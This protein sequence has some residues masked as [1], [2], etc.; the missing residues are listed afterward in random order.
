MYTRYPEQRKHSGWHTRGETEV[1]KSNFISAFALA[2][3]SVANILM[4]LPLATTELPTCNYSLVIK[5]KNRVCQNRAT[6]FWAVDNSPRLSICSAALRSGKATF[7]LPLVL[8][9]SLWLL[10]FPSR[11]S[12]LPWSSCLFCFRLYQE[13]CHTYWVLERANRCSCCRFPVSWWHDLAHLF[14]EMAHAGSPQSGLE[15]KRTW[16]EQRCTHWTGL[17]GGRWLAYVW[18]GGTGSA[19]LGSTSNFFWWVMCNQWDWE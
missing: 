8:V 13:Q 9:A 3:F 1:G 17:S 18:Q 19:T 10:L 5:T 11:P 12:P 2:D 16:R 6:P 15:W 7:L 4:A 14:L